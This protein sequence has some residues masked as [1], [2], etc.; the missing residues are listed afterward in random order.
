MGY[1]APKDYEFGWGATAP[2]TPGGS[3]SPVSLLSAFQFAADGYIVGAR[4]FRD[5][6]DDFNHVAFITNPT[7]GTVLRCQ[8]FP[9][10]AASGSGAGAWETV[11]FARRFPVHQY[12]IW[13]LGVWFGGSYFWYDAGAL[14]SNGFVNAHVATLQ[15]GLPYPNMQFSYSGVFDGFSS[16]SGSRYG[17][18]VSFWAHPL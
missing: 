10:R 14:S 16:S 1:A 4:Y 15:D 3:G 8:P 18:D 2:S 9:R 12:D 17:I 6:A 5:L 13:A 11:Y 7:D